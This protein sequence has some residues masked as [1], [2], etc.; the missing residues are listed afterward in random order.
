M[1]IF[2]F[3]KR[4]TLMLSL[5]CLFERLDYDSSSDVSSRNN[6]TIFSFH[7]FVLL[8]AVS[9]KEITYFN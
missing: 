5:I 4:E 2:D 6:T 1:V 3:L 8:S 9:N 7:D